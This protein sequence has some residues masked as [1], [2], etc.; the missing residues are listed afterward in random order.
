MLRREAAGWLS[1]LQ[2]RREPNIERKFRQWHD[3]DARHAAAFDR[4]RR[5][6]DQAGLLRHSPIVGS[7]QFESDLARRGWKLRPAFAAIAV[8]ALL[9]PVAAFLV[10]GG[11][12]PFTST[13]AVMLITRA[14]ETRQVD[15]ADGSKVKLDS[16]TKV[17]V[18][19]GRSGRS[20]HLRYGRARFQITESSEPFVLETGRTTITARQGII[21]IEQGTKEDRVQVLAGSA[22][23]HA[24][25]QPDKADVALAAGESATVS[26][27]GG[28]QMTVA[29][30]AL[31]QTRAMLQFDGTP[32]ADAVALA[33]LHSERH[34]ILVGD[35]N[36]L[37]VTGAFRAG[38]TAALAKALAAAFALSLEQR[39]D[40]NFVLSR[41][42]SQ[43]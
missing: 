1:R 30:A 21:D 20:A 43:K 34:I 3:A 22:D 5:T 7:G 6:Y 16:A 19:I 37:R 26:S 15:L 23:L 9:L 8:L 42:A 35:F 39:G 41:I 14:G 40:G 10:R 4:V 27:S 31:N 11:N 13:D 38:D 18:E 32:L 28:Q 25:G 12:L 29:P 17:E 36:K 33:N 24:S 2:S